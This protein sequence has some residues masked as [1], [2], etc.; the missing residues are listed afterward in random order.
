LTSRGG[1][2]QFG[3]RLIPRVRIALSK[4]GEV[5]TVTTDYI[6]VQLAYLPATSRLRCRGA[7]NHHLFRRASFTKRFING[8]KRT[9]VE[10]RRCC[11]TPA[12]RR[13]IWPRCSGHRK[14]A[15]R[16]SLRP[17]LRVD[18]ELFV[19]SGA[20]PVFVDI[21]ED[22]LN[23]DDGDRGRHHAAHAVDRA[24]APTP[25]FVRLDSHYCDRPASRPW[26]LETRRQGIMAAIKARAGRDRRSRHV[27]FFTNQ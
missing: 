22:T 17:T 5:E 23:L 26:I 15:T 6:L 1:N 27:H 11:P 10:P 9:P 12:R 13:G 16:Y 21:R 18:R 2:R 25:P 19:L 20:V 7:R 24:G 4:A 8:S 14:S 3:G